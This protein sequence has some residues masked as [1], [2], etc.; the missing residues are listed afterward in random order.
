MSKMRR[1]AHPFVC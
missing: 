1:T